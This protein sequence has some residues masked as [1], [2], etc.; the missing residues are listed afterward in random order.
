MQ[1][2]F[3]SYT[4]TFLVWT[5]QANGMLQLSMW[6]ALRDLGQGA[7]L[8]YYNP[9]VDVAVRGLFD[10]PASMS[11]GHRCPSAPSSPNLT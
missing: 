3:A 9:V 1:N 7:N 10:V 8:Q 5:D 6:S 2:R 11:C 4:D